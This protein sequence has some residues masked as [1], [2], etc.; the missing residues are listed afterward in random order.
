MTKTLILMNGALFGITAIVFIIFVGRAKRKEDPKAQAKMEAKMVKRHNYYQKFAL[1]RT[2]YASYLK[3]F[4]IYGITSEKELAMQAVAAF[5]VSVGVTVGLVIFGLVVLQNVIYTLLLGFFGYVFIQK[6]LVKK[7]DKIVAEVYL[8]LSSTVSLFR[9]S[10]LST[11]SVDKAFVTTKIPTRLMPIFDQMR[12]IIVNQSEEELR[13]LI[14]NY[15]ITTVATLATTLYL[16]S[17]N[18]AKPLPGGG[19][20]LDNTLLVIE[21]ECD[22]EYRNCVRVKH[23]FAMMDIMALLG[24][25]VWPAAELFMKNQ[26]PGLVVLLEG[27]YGEVVHLL[28]CVATIFSYSYVTNAARL[29]VAASTDVSSIMVAISTNSFVNNVVSNLAPKTYMKRQ[30][31]QKKLST[32]SSGKSLQYFYTE[33]LIYFIGGFIISLLALFWAS[34]TVRSNFK[35][36]YDSLSLI[37]ATLTDTQKG[38]LKRFDDDFLKIPMSEYEEKYQTDDEELARIVTQSIRGLGIMEVNEQVSRIRTKYE[39]YHNS[40]PKFWFPLVALAVAIGA[41]FMPDMSIKKRRKDIVAET[42]NEVAS[43]QALMIVLSYSH[44]SCDEALR[45]LEMQSKV[46]RVPLRNALTIYKRNPDQAMDYL[47]SCSDSEA[48]KHIVHKL[49]SCIYDIS[50]SSAFADM[51]AQRQQTS[52]IAELS[53][54]DSLEKKKNSARLLSLLPAGGALLG[55]FIAPVLILGLQQMSAVT[56]GLG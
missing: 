6:T 53:R 36:N 37:P 33:K 16:N 55:C 12:K 40:N 7:A 52:T 51:S 23:A 21:Q 27:I 24:L 44:A 3:S 10:Y 11:N 47:S 28:I 2:L 15:P 17:K 19:D 34:F 49:R 56:S 54:Q 13:G 32:A 43:L 8:E 4:S 9:Q 26:I 22:A 48:F 39:T 25:V 46:L 30:H 31:V 38:Q 45:L 41:W 14:D 18:G 50:I 20:S 1:T 35:N 5:D 29:S 42:G